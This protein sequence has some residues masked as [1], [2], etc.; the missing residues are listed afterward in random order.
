[1]TE[2][3][4]KMKQGIIYVVHG[5]PAQESKQ[6]TE[7]ILRAGKKYNCPQ[8]IAYLA[9]DVETLED[10]IQEL[11][12][13]DQ[14]IFLPMLLY[15]ATHYIYDLPPR[16]KKMRAE[17]ED[18][19]LPPLAQTESYQQGIIRRVEDAYHEE[20]LDVVLA[21][22]GTRH[23][24]EPEEA[25]RILAQEIEQRLGCQVT[26]ADIA[27]E[28]PFRQVLSFDEKRWIEPLF[29]TDGRLVHKMKDYAKE[30]APNAKWLDTLEGSQLL[31][32]MI[33]ESLEGELHVSDND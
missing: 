21:V 4:V 31:I 23:F 25:Q 5:R 28:N 17:K 26:I 1:M 8:K 14:L 20:P 18:I 9:G 12:D 15:A 24:K 29:L 33:S 16:V 3:R 22:H 2:W 11:D 13:C 6:N 30:H 10:A 19:I 32:D 7:C 27:G